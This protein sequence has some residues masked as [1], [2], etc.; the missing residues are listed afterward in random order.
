MKTL[1]HVWT[2]PL[3]LALGLLTSCQSS[4]MGTK[5]EK[6]GD[7]YTVSVHSRMLDNHL[8]VLERNVRRRNDLLEAQ[9]RGQNVSRKDLQFEYRYVW[10][11]ADGFPVDTG[12]SVWKPLNLR[13]RDT[14][15]MNGIS[16]DPNAVDFQMAVRF[17]HKSNRWFRP[18]DSR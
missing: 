17:A 18:G 7:L 4:S 8:V 10:I 2:L 14:A 11:D 3:L 9:V 16:P 13:A 5:V 6:H 15:W 12:M 1:K